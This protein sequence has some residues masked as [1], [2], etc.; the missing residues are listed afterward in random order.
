MARRLDRLQV[1]IL[2]D[3]VGGSLVASYQDVRF[4]ATNPDAIVSD[5]Q[6]TKA[7]FEGHLTPPAFDGTVTVNALL[8]TL[9]NSARTEAGGATE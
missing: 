7:P 3:R 1:T 6:V 5:P 4:L 8:T 2:V 9:R